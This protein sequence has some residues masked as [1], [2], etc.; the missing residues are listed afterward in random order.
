MTK[1][2]KF[3]STSELFSRACIQNEDVLFAYLGDLDS[4]QASNLLLIKSIRTKTDQKKKEPIKHK[5]INLANL[6]SGLVYISI[7]KPK[8][9]LVLRKEKMENSKKTYTWERISVSWAIPEIE[10]VSILTVKSASKQLD[11]SNLSLI[12]LCPV[13]TYI[14]LVFQDLIFTGQNQ[15]V[16]MAQI[17]LLVLEI[18][19]KN[20]F[21]F[22]RYRRDLSN[23]G[24][25]YCS[26]NFHNYSRGSYL[27]LTLMTNEKKS[28]AVTILY[29]CK[30][31][32]V[33]TTRQMTT[34]AY[35]P[36]NLDRVGY[37]LLGL[38]R[39]GRVISVSL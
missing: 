32:R 21:L 30:M 36:S 19:H 5:L 17:T 37:D 23:E 7:L 3:F 6:F 25:Q 39:W 31:N 15:A 28:R 11:Y 24:A 2:L 33:L 27:G 12:A 20:G 34:A 10:S 18:D 1:E 9:L 22:E 4:D 8:T 29:D 14:A 35:H 13:G 26:M 16:M 38:D